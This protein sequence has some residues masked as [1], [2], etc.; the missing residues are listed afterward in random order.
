MEFP[1]LKIKAQEYYADW[2]PDALIVEAKASG[3]PLV[4]ELRAMGIPV[5]EFT[6]VEVMIR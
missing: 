3:A 1:E 2:Q 6:P 4:F 5:S